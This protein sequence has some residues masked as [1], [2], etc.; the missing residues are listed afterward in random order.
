MPLSLS[1]A[2]GLAIARL[3]TERGWT[4]D[5]LARRVSSYRPVVCRVMRGAHP[6][7]LGTVERY[8]EAFGIKPSELLAAAEE[9]QAS[10][11]EL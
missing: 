4:Q 1:Q 6:Q 9:I 8:A 2:V 11:G 5:E 3:R 7:G 10:G